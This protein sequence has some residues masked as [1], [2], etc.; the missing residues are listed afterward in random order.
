MKRGNTRILRCPPGATMRCAS[1]SARTRE[2]TGSACCSRRCVCPPRLKKTRRP[3]PIRR[4]SKPPFTAPTA[5]ASRQWSCWRDGRRRFRRVQRQRKTQ[6]RRR[7]Q[8][9]HRIQRRRKVR[10]R[11]R[12]RHN[13]KS[14]APARTRRNSLL[15]ASTSL[16]LSVGTRPSRAAAVFP[17]RRQTLRQKR[18]ILHSIKRRKSHPVLAGKLN[19]RWSKA[20]Q[21]EQ[22]GG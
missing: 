21:N 15:P 16:P 17:D 11:H 13:A 14:V 20:V 22:A 1:R 18:N 6:R 12:K 5:S 4:R 3:R 7:A 10:E 9:R 19:G 8:S 2:K